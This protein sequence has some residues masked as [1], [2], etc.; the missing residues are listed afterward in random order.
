[1]IRKLQTAQWIGPVFVLA[2][3]TVWQTLREAR[4]GEHE[5]IGLASF[6]FQGQTTASGEPFDSNA[7]TGAH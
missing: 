7:L 5:E 2:L 3:I 6:Y 1:M 4:A